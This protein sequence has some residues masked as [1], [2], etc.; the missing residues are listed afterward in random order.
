MAGTRKET[1]ILKEQPLS[2]PQYLRRS[3]LMTTVS[4]RQKGH[5]ATGGGVNYIRGSDGSRTGNPST[6]MSLILNQG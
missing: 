2:L 5:P 6:Q 3:S 4:L 1:Q